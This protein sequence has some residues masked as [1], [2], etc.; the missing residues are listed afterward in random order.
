MRLGPRFQEEGWHS[1]FVLYSYFSL[2]ML[3]R[4][5]YFCISVCHWF[6]SRTVLPRTGLLMS[7]DKI[8]KFI[9]KLGPHF[10]CMS[11]ESETICLLK[12]Q[13]LGSRELLYAQ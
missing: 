7:S 2:A 11:S 3:E 1:L 6:K 8:K 13:G 9:L 12:I 4:S 5:S 10:L